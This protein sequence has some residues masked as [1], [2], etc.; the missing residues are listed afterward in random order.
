MQ[1]KYDINGR[2]KVFTEGVWKEK[3][4]KIAKFIDETETEKKI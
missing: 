4:I 3:T 2:N 1:N